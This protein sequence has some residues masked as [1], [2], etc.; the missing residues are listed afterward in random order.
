[1]KIAPHI[2]EKYPRLLEAAKFTVGR[3]E[4]GSLS[5][6]DNVS[7]SLSIIDAETDKLTWEFHIE[8]HHCNQ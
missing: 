2:A 5:W 1:M 8:H 6:E 7:T 3:R 4:E